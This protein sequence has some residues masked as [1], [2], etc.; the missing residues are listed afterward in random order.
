MYK[1]KHNGICKYKETIYQN[2]FLP[3]TFA[4][5]FDNNGTI[6][7]GETFEN[8]LYLPLTASKHLLTAK[9]AWKQTCLDIIGYNVDHVSAST[10]QTALQSLLDCAR[11]G[12]NKGN[13]S[14]FVKAAETNKLS[15][16][17]S[18]LGFAT[19]VSHIIRL[20]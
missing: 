1:E 17:C 11:T 18:D 14:A 19:G 10:M 9:H 15:I 16:R 8:I 12:P 20:D 3:L 2:C 6:D 7:A 13:M 4:K 5:D